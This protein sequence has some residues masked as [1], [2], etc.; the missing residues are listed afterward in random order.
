MNGDEILW[1]RVF[2][3]LETLIKENKE[4]KDAL[5]RSEQ[6]LT[7]YK[8]MDR[9]IRETMVNAVAIGEDYKNNAKKEA[10]LILQGARLKAK[11]VD[12]ESE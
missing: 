12:K 1:R 10:E 3:A 11:Q 2:L 7:E 8:D 6:A 5:D 4:L 9:S